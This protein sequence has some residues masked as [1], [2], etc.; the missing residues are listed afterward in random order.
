MK[1]RA[2]AQL[3]EEMQHDLA[4]YGHSPLHQLLTLSAALDVFSEEDT[5]HAGQT[6]LPELLSSLFEILPDVQPIGCAPTVLQECRRVAH[7]AG[8]LCMADFSQDEIRL[9]LERLDLLERHGWC[10]TGMPW[11][12]DHALGAAFLATTKPSGTP[13]QTLEQFTAFLLERGERNA[14]LYRRMLDDWDNRKSHS[15]DTAILPLLV[16]LPLSS[17]VRPDDLPGR[18]LTLQC[19]LTS[20]DSGA[21]VDNISVA[22]ILHGKD[23]WRFEGHVQRAVDAARALSSRVHPVLGARRYDVRL[24]FQAMDVIYEGISFQLPLAALLYYQML[25]P[26]ER[27]ATESLSMNVVLT[28]GID[29]AG[30]TLPTGGDIIRR[31]LMTVFFSPATHFVYPREDE[32]EVNAVLDAL[33]R[34]YPYRRLRTV[35]ARDLRDVAGNRE[36]VVTKEI[37]LAT[38]AVAALGRNAG[39]IAAA[40][41]TLLLL[42]VAYSFLFV[43]DFDNNP[44]DVFY[45]EFDR[46][47]YVRNENGRVLWS[48]S[49]TTPNRPLFVP[50]FRSPQL[51]LVVDVDRDGGNEVILGNGGCLVDSSDHIT[52]YNADQ[53]IRWRTKLGSPVETKEGDYRN[54]VPAADAMVLDTSAERRRMFVSTVSTFYPTFLY[55]VD[56]QGRITDSYLHL[57]TLRELTL[58]TR[59][60]GGRRVLIAAGF[61][62]SFRRACLVIFDPD[63]IRGCSP[64]TERYR[65]IEPRYTPGSELYYIT[66][67]RTELSELV[68]AAGVCNAHISSIRDSVID[69]AIHQFYTP[70]KGDP[71]EIFITLDSRLR[72]V[73]MRTSS[74]FDSYHARHLSSGE[75][76]H[77]IDAAYQREFLKGIRYWNGKS[78]Q[79]EPTMVKRR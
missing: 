58:T 74:N 61:S 18:L 24:A 2:A 62:N 76:K 27:R 54:V 29:D 48:R 13:R 45:D 35:P 37:P 67:P 22:N 16:Q 28:G 10:F 12:E 60:F 30:A 51:A 41:F 8:N 73:S 44:A 17:I 46:M 47:L 77:P 5:R 63:S 78:F 31:K 23:T 68:F 55:T 53:S 32:A 49:A 19:G 59:L 39:K 56:L 43:W 40:S 66:F 75:L 14:P 38:R 69:I 50:A 20:L 70:A 65:L 11:G 3:F 6:F 36:I 42:V 1:A 71:V 34:I 72:A 4:A 79:A 52:C 9:G 26:W 25:R 57:G 33:Q 21:D 64:P 15:S 7:R